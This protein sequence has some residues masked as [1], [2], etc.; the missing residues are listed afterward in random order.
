MTEIEAIKEFKERIELIEK[1]YRGEAGDYKEVLEIGVKAL[2]KQ[3]PKKPINK[4][5]PDDYA[6]LAYENCNIV[7]CPDCG[8]RLKLKSKGKYCDKC[9]Q[10]LDWRGKE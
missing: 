6:S 5:R 10:K 1:C 3:I 4:T 2:E 9:G 8:R 7:V